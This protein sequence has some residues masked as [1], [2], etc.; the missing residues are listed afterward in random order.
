M[1]RMRTRSARDYDD[2]R[3]TRGGGPTSTD[4]EQATAGDEQAAQPMGTLALVR[5]LWPF[6]L[7]TAV[8][9]LA[10]SGA[11]LFMAPMAA[12]VGTTTAF[13]G[14]LRALSGIAALL[15]AD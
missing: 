2:I 9:G 11:S 13:V 14:G 10:Q 15:V 4:G 6:L 7:A 8:A 5:H 12:D 3:E 1:L